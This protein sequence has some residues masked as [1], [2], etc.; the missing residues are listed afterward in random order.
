MVILQ[1]YRAI[2]RAQ[3][4]GRSTKMTSA[5][6][7]GHFY[8]VPTG[9]LRRLPPT[10]KHRPRSRCAGGDLYVR[11]KSMRKC[12]LIRSKRSRNHLRMPLSKRPPHGSNLGKSWKPHAPETFIRYVL[13]LFMAI[14]LL[15]LDFFRT[16][17]RVSNLASSPVNGRSCRLGAL[18]YS[19][20]A[21]SLRGVAYSRLARFNLRAHFLTRR[22]DLR[23]SPR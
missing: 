12:R 13:F 6:P 4:K 17:G 8:A 9:E 20:L 5:V 23:F 10:S 16:E 22:Y 11:K 7:L 21:P 18:A 2:A 15:S 14:H 3:K 1:S 19:Q